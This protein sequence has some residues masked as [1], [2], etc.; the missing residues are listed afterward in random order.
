MLDTTVL[1]GN[2]TRFDQRLNIYPF[3]PRLYIKRGMLHFKLGRLTD[4][5]KDFN[6]AEELNPQLTPY[7]WQRGLTYYYLGKYAKAARQFELHLSIQ[8]QD[9]HNTLWFFL[10]MAQL[11]DI[12]MARDCLLPVGDNIDSYMQNIYLAFAG[13]YNL[14]NLIHLNDDFDRIKNM[15]MGDRYHLFYT[16]FY[17]GL[18]CD[19]IGDKNKSAFLIDKAINYPIEDYMWY[20]A[21]THQSLNKGKLSGGYKVNRIS[22]F[23]N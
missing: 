6:K 7:L 17:A 12:Y 2:L 15:P 19:V 23:S 3:E 11:E 1:E 9:I 22:G 20:V 18:Y 5:L 16:N 14:N 21:C 4:S 10:A 13:R 8:S